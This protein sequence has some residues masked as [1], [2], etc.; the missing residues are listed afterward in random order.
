MGRRDRPGALTWRLVD[1][2]GRTSRSVEVELPVVGDGGL[3]QVD[4]RGVEPL[5]PRAGG[6]YD[7]GQLV[8][9]GP[10]G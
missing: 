6:A 5:Y 10:D 2:A 9:T 7:S 8:A 3:L 1:A 4:D